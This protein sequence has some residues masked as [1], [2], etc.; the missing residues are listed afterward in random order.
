MSR[1]FPCG[2]GGLGNEMEVEKWKREWKG[3]E[4]KWRTWKKKKGGGR[5]EV[6]KRVGIRRK[7]GG[8]RRESGKAQGRERRES[9]ERGKESKWGGG[10]RVEVEGMWKSGNKAR[11]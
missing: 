5:V 7:S 9:G 1:E 4:E 3:S 8:Q 10:G 2:A 6:E 11:E